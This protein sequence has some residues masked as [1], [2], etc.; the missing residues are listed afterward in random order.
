MTY[1]VLFWIC[2]HTDKTGA[3]SGCKCLFCVK[4]Y[5]YIKSASLV[6]KTAAI[7]KVACIIFE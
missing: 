7:C 4:I 3:C 2:V 1:H 5:V 6:Q